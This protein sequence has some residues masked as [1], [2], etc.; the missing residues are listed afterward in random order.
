MFRFKSPR[1]A[2]C[3]LVFAL[4]CLGCLSCSRQQVR[5]RMDPED[6]L[7]LA[8]QLRSQDKCVSAVAEYEK[9]LSEFPAPQVAESAR[10]NLAVCRLEL[11]QYDLAR[12]EFEDFIDSHPKSDLIDNALYMIAM[13]YLRAAPR[14]ERDQSN[15]INAMNELLLLLREYPDTD[16]RSDAEEAIAECRSQLAKKEYLAG[17]LYLKMK[18]YRA[19][20]VYLDSVL[21][22]YRD[23]PWAPRALI[24]KGRAYIGEKRLEEAEAAFRQVIEEFPQSDARREATRE[25]EDLKHVLPAGEERASEE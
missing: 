5:D 12:T 13:S 22:T 9:L 4:L 7:I 24:L 23:T 8:D 25:L 18:D 14:A 3:P 6:R 21:E 2:V 16:V 19:A 10:F 17:E 15:T 1:S 11:E 20:H